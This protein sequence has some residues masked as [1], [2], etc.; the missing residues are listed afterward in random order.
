MDGRVGGAL[1]GGV[2]GCVGEVL[3]QTAVLPSG[4]VASITCDSPWSLMLS[5]KLP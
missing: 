1:F 3:V 2:G 5:S 4:A